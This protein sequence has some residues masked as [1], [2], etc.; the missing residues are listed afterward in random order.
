[1]P[2]FDSAGNP[3]VTLAG[4]R[5]YRFLRGLLRLWFT[6]FFGNCRLLGESTPAESAGVI[7]LV[8]HP[9][10]FL[11]ALI[12]AATFDREVRCLVDRKMVRNPLERLLA[13]GLEMI[14]YEAGGEDWASALAVSCDALAGGC[15]VITFA[16]PQAPQTAGPPRFALAAATIA[17]EAEA[18]HAGRLDLKIC[19]V[20][21]FLP[22]AP[23]RAT[24]LVIYVDRPLSARAYL[25][26][27][28]AA[29]ML[30]TA[31]GAACRES[32]F[33]MQAAE[34]T[35][36]LADLEQMLRRD[37]EEDWGSRPGWKQ[38]LEGFELSPFV[39]DSAEQANTLHPGRLAAVRE[40]LD[41]YRDARRV[42]WRREFE[43]EA[44]P[45]ALKSPWRQFVAWAESVVGLPVVLYGLLNHL[46][47]GLIL[48]PIELLTKR[49]DWSRRLR[50]ATR[51]AVALLCYVVQ[52]GACAY[53]LGGAAAGYYAASLPIS[54]AYLLRYKWLL[55]QRMP[56]MYFAA[57]R[58]PRKAQLV[59]LRKQVSIDLNAIR[60][61]YAGGP[62][63]P[64]P[65]P[66]GLTLGRP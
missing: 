40:S 13:K 61:A 35:R 1:V 26:Q 3:D 50:W 38:T 25:S 37:L 8:N 31:V 12:L 43:F 36:L 48:L 52:I 45:A 65:Q 32:P 54:A 20:H 6:L 7:L 17:L 63:I 57:T 64:P 10:G 9:A 27:A 22:V 24:E 34:F 56:L 51:G 66:A 39:K 14:L 2:G 59:R 60:D 5:T 15:A 29:P 62:G 4:S 28:E 47:V 16:E 33:R 42:W 18:R 53:F 23:S 41:Q 19:P 49:R 30:A 11:D 46:L 44:A 21:L 58:S 55:G